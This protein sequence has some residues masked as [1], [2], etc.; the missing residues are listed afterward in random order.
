MKNTRLKTILLVENDVVVAETDAETVRSFGYEVISANCKERAIELASSGE[1]IDLILL[2]I[3][4]ES[5]LD[6]VQTAREILCFREVPIV[7][8]TSHL[9]K[10][11]VD[12]GQDYPSLRVCSQG[13]RKINLVV[14]DGNGVGAVRGAPNAAAKRKARPTDR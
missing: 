4:L 6:G 3:D 9:E 11:I 12:S 5:P 7:F 8:F 10:E 2:D 13:L 14:C 1:E